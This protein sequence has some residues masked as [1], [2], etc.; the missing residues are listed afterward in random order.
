MNGYKNSHT[1]ITTPHAS[2]A[3]LE[4]VALQSRRQSSEHVLVNGH[5]LTI[6]DVVAVSL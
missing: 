2:A 3:Y 5:E 4:W 6:A 1:G